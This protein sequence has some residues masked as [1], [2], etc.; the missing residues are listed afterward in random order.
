MEDATA[1]RKIYAENTLKDLVSL[2]PRE[3]LCSA[4]CFIELFKHHPKGN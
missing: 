4:A 3:Y 2:E 1:K